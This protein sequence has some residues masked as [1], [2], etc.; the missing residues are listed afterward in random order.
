MTWRGKPSDF[1]ALVI[2]D[3]EKYI[4]KTA[5]VAFQ[6]VV[7]SS[8]VMDGAFR[9]NHRISINTIDEGFD[10][11]KQDVSGSATLAK[12]NAEILKAKIG[13]T[14]F[15]QNNAPYALRLENGWSM[16]APKGIYSIAFQKM[17][18]SK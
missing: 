7:T 16:Q 4:Q 11:K 14:V 15:I 3:C 18:N 5:A 6:Q 10:K 9:G 1:S 17:S 13:D 12:G 2:K 8:P